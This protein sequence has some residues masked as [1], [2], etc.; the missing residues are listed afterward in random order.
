MD[1]FVRE[2]QPDDAAAI[3]NILN[4]IIKT[5]SYTALTTPFSLEAERAFILNFPQQGIFHVAVCRQEQR[6]VGCQNVEPFAT[7]TPAFNHVGVIGTF[8]D[9]D[10]RRKGVGKSL[11]AATFEAARCKGYEKLFAYVRAD[12]PAALAAY[13]SQGFQEIGIARRHAKIDGAYV[14]EVMIERFL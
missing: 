1:V 7:Y 10:Y 12:N 13:M 11:F 4:P 5:G 6:I 9:L 2:A 3:I 8:V 14:D